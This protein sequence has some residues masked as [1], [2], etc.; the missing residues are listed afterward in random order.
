MTTAAQPALAK[1][2]IRRADW[3]ALAIAASD[4]AALETAFLLGLTVRRTLSTWFIAYIGLDQYFAVAIA[5]LLLPL[6]YYQLGL[7]PGYLLSPVER[8]RRRTLS[9]LAVFGGLLAWDNIVERGV[10]S[11]G[12]LLATFFFA[13]V[14]PPLADSLA[15]AVLVRSRRWG[16]P[17]VMIGAGD[18]ARAVARTL[19]R[20]PQLGLIPIAFLDNRPEVWNS[21]I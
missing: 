2:R 15:R 21:R 18:T 8:L 9:T 4:V 12:V 14:L 16:L 10:L 19:A 17:V 11:R 5:I 3:T 20:D 6:I 13:L 7:Y 1:P